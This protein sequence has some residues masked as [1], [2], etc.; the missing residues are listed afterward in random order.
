VIFASP[1]SSH[2]RPC[3]GVGDGCAVWSLDRGS[4]G[5][6]INQHVVLLKRA[7]DSDDVAYVVRIRDGTPSWYLRCDH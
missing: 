5:A 7:K 1:V 2:G 3:E 4:H 6:G